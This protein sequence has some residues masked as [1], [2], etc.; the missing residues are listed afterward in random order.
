M[1]HPGTTTKGLA[2]SGFCDGTPRGGQ[3]IISGHP[4]GGSGCRVGWEIY[5]TDE[6]NDWL[7]GLLKHDA[8]SHPQVV[9]AHDALADASPRLAR[10]STG[11]RCLLAQ[12]QGV[13]SRI[14]W[15]Q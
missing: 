7:D 2:I 9:S 14:N 1:V 6:V 5:L 12:P 15:S 3:P 10:S 13:V 8:D 4:P 11:S